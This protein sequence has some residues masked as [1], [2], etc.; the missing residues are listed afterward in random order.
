MV[1]FDMSGL[2]FH[3]GFHTFTQYLKYAVPSQ[4]RNGTVHGSIRQLKFSAPYR[5]TYISHITLS[6]RF[7]QQFVSNRLCLDLASH[8]SSPRFHHQVETNQIWLHLTSLVPGSI[9]VSKHSHNISSLRFHHQFVSSRIRHDLTSQVLGS[10]QVS[11][12]SHNISCF[13]FH[14]K[15]V[16]NLVWLVSTTQ[17]HAALHAY[18]TKAQALG[19]II[20]LHQTW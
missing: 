10:I 5:F 6:P 2:R 17:F 18:H 1:R 8:V 9:H 7:H 15:F 12:H 11:I 19:S 4:V 14:Y 3:T 16:A 13:L 20:S